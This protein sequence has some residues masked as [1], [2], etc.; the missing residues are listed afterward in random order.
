MIFDAKFTEQE[1]NLKASFGVLTKGEKGDKGDKGDTGEISLAFAE[2]SYAPLIVSSA[3]GEQITI[4]DSAK[5]G[6][7]GLK[8]YGKTTQ[9][10]TPTPDNPIPLESV[11]GDGTVVTTVE[12]AILIPDNIEDGS[13]GIYEGKLV[14]YISGETCH[15]KGIPLKAGTYTVSGV[16]KLYFY[17]YDE[18]GVVDLTKTTAQGTPSPYTFTVDT[19]CYCGVTDSRESLA[20]YKLNSGYT[21][22][23]YEPDYEPQQLI[24]TTPNGLCGIPVSSGGNYTDKDGRQWRCDEIDF[25]RG[26][27]KRRT[28]LVQIL[29]PSRYA[30]FMLYFLFFRVYALLRSVHPFEMFFYW[31][32][33]PF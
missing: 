19:N 6:F 21:P 29:P 10:G 25:E 17:V 4:T 5:R 8:I 24:T 13:L 9:N 12:G 15:I 7:Q 28:G 22:L 26:V 1:K 33:L 14:S 2:S 31:E 27:T 18:N 20:K 23:P 32:S 30:C 3:E 11:G 16:D